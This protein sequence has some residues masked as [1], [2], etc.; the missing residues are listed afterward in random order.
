MNERNSENIQKNQHRP[1]CGP[2]PLCQGA[3]RSRPSEAYPGQA[4][5]VQSRAQKGRSRQKKAGQGQ[6]M[7]GSE[8]NQAKG[9][10]V[11]QGKARQVQVKIRKL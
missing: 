5:Q 6:S 9:N 7:A 1:N 2:K 3:V 4:R 8:V 10:K 11:G